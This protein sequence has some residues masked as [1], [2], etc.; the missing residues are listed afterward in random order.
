MVTLTATAELRRAVAGLSSLAQRDLAELWRRVSTAA[1]AREAL[2]DILPALVETYGAAAATLAAD[3]Y[4]DQRDKYGAGRFTAIPAEIRDP[5][6]SALI[7]WATTTATSDDA[8]RALIEGGLQKRIANASRQTVIGSA[9]ADPSAVGWKR[10]GAGACAFCRMLIQ[11]DQLYTE[12]TADFASHDHCNCQAY[13][14]IKGA[15][16]IDVREY[17]KSERNLTDADRARVR[18]WIAEHDL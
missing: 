15:E 16:P 10:I 1:Q 17:V 7:G 4:D 18:K 12:A 11:R 14:L 5:G 8:F 13:P 9:I 2:E 3:W 6:A